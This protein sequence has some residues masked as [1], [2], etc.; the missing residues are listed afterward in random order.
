MFKRL[1]L[2]QIVLE[3]FALILSGGALLTTFQHVDAAAQNLSASIVFAGTLMA[4]ALTV[5]TIP[6][7]MP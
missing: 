7:D 3:L 1:L 5:R 6:R 4:F 2:T